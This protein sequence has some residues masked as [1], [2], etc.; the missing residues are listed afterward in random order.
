MNTANEKG[1]IGSIDIPMQNFFW[2]LRPWKDGTMVTIDGNAR[3]SEMSFEGETRVKMKPLLEFPKQA[4][5]RTLCAFPEHDLIISKSSRRFHVADTST[6]KT[7]SFAPY[8]TGL[9]SEQYPILLDGKKGLVAF[10][11]LAMDDEKQ[12]DFFVVHNYKDGTTTD[13]LG[14]TKNESRKIYYPIDSENIIT[15]TFKGP[16]SETYLYNWKTGER[17]DNELTKTMS[18]LGLGGLSLEQGVNIDLEKRVLFV[19]IYPP[20]HD[21][22]HYARITWDEGYKDVKVVPLNYLV[23]KNRW[24]ND[25]FLSPCGTW[26]TSYIDGYRGMYNESLVKRVFFHLDDLYPN[27]ISMPIF[28]EGYD[29]YHWELGSFV[30]HPVHGMCFAEKFESKADGKKKEFLRLYKMKDVDAEITRILL[31]RANARVLTK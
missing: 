28:T 30:N 31:E 25:I 7:N 12:N 23:P 19:Q 18:G 24:L 2:M 26:A 27:G 20:S 16:V 13:I 22:S 17:T 8:L 4:L 29:T 5:D 10:Q 6:G 3:F 21:I 11:Y 15:Q 9:H 1:A 14:E